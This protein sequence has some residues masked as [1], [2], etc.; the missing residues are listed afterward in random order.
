MAEEVKRILAAIEKAIMLEV[1]ELTRAP[2]NTI[3]ATEVSRCIR[4]SFYSRIYLK[5]L[6]F[7]AAYTILR[8]RLLH[9]VVLRNM[10]LGVTETEEGTRS[11]VVEDEAGKVEVRGRADMVVGD[12]IVD[13]KTSERAPDKLPEEYRGQ[14]QLY[15]E[16]YGRSKGLVVYITREG[17]KYFQENRDEGRIA[18][19]KEKALKLSRAL[20]E[21]KPPEPEVGFWC[22]W[23]SWST[24]ELCPEGYNYKIGKSSERG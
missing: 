23:C 15:M 16:L 13:L 24:Q 10:P 9:E 17:L 6:D 11:I 20:R 7:G 18:K 21:N 1:S 14:V 19:L 8:G 12:Y 2:P 3:W 5:S 4:Q 22:R